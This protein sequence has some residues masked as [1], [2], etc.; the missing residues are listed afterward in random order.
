MYPVGELRRIHPNGRVN[1][2]G[3]LTEA[4]GREPGA[5]RAKRAAQEL[6]SAA[7]EADVDAAMKAVEAGEEGERDACV[8][9]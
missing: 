8:A 4:D 1:Y 6:S 5:D 2:E 3:Q 9:N 7:L